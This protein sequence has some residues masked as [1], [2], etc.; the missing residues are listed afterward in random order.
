MSYKVAVASSDGKVVNQHFGRAEQ[1]LII[2][3]D[4]EGLFKLVEV[5][6]LNRVCNN[7]EH[8]EEDMQ[9]RVSELTDCK[10]V[11][12]S[13]I[14]QGAENILEAKGISAYEIP[15]FIEDALT[16]LISYVEINKLI[17][18]G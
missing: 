3:V 7:G 17:Y 14:G 8:D 16:K 5:R 13:R 1:F 10:Y 9:K 18:G 4:E 12:V 2:E 11:L 6:K 15:D